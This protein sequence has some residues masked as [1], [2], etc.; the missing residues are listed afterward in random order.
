MWRHWVL[1]KVR[2]ERERSTGRGGYTE[3]QRSA[4]PLVHHKYCP[5]TVTWSMSLT[6]KRC[7]GRYSAGVEC[8][9]GI[10]YEQ[11]HQPWHHMPSRLLNMYVCLHHGY[12]PTVQS[13]FIT[14]SSPSSSCFCSSFCCWSCC[15]CWSVSSSSSAVLR[16][17]GHDYID[18]SAQWSARNCLQCDCNSHTRSGDIKLECATLFER[19]IPELM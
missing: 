7:S 9:Y 10:H 17:E 3:Q 5:V 13:C 2:W 19:H 8:C 6:C 14:S 4:Q 11:C 12:C 16:F 18:K 15:F 1:Y